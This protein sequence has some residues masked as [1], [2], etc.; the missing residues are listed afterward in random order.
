MAV[1]IKETTIED[2]QNVV[3]LWNDG[4]VMNYVGFPEGLGVTKQDLINK[5]YPTINNDVYRRHFSIYDDD[6]GYCGE[7][8]YDSRH[9]EKTV[10]DIKLLPKARGRGLGE[11]GL[12]H[13]IEEAFNHGGARMVYVDP[14]KN[15]KKALALYH[16]LNFKQLPHPDCSLRETH[17][18]L[19]LYKEAYY[20]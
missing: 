1:H 15:N 12:R 8:Y 9:P 18:Y 11:I 17:L 20:K 6:I 10:L 14:N 3:T 13:A 16:K 2:L 7:S 19:T 4:D 5:W